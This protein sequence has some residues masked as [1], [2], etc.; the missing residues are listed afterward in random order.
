MLALVDILFANNMTK[1]Y[2]LAY[3]LHRIVS[4]DPKNNMV[5]YVGSLSLLVFP[6]MF[7]DESWLANVSVVDSDSAKK[8][9]SLRHDHLHRLHLQQKEDQF[10]GSKKE[11]SP[12]KLSPSDKYSS[13]TESTKSPAKGPPTDPQSKRKTDIINSMSLI[14]SGTSMLSVEM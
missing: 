11:S 14:R 9:M 2:N 8:L 1:S 13:P 10:M 3:K 7:E 4:E 12:D 5:D 6:T